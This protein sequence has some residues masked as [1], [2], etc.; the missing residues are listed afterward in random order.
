MLRLI[1]E[2]PIDKNNLIIIELPELFAE[3]EKLFDLKETIIR[4]KR[5]GF[6][7][8][9]V[10]NSPQFSGRKNYYINNQIINEASLELIKNKV[11]IDMP[12]EAEKSKYEEAKNWV[13]NAVDNF[14]EMGEREGKTIQKIQLLRC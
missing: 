11:L 1:S 9:M 13:F 4:M 10:T 6:K 5:R 2:Q 8:L 7:F 3:Q 12:F 14:N